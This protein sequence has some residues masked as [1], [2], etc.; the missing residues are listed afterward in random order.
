MEKLEKA[1]YLEPS[2]SPYSAPIVCIKKPDGSL[3][4]NIDFR[5]V[6]NNVVNNA[7]PMNHVED[8]LEAMSKDSAF[9]TLDLT[10]R[11]HHIKLAEES[12]EI[13]A[14]TSPRGLF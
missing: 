5:M 6:S 10:K 14:F 8:Q 9:S 4:V 13:N 2:K 1:D 3:R 11:Y 7:H 12:K